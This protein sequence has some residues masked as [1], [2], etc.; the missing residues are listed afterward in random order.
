MDE[1]VWLQIQDFPDYSVS[2][3]GRIRNDVR[4]RFVQTSHTNRGA[5]KVGLTS[6]GKQQTRQVKDLVAA[7]FVEGYNDRFNT[8]VILDGDHDN[9]NARNLAWR[10]YWF[11]WKYVNQFKDINHYL[12]SGPIE[13][14]KTGVRYS[15][16]VDAGLTNGLL[17]YEIQLALVRKVPVFPTWHLFDWVKG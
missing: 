10:P 9:L 12:D 15:N 11:N 13:D 6:G 1:E 14:R 5:V 7:A 3:H 17:F 8:V 4:R 2:S 16:I